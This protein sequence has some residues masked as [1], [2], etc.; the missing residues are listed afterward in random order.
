MMTVMNRYNGW[1][2]V[3]KKDRETMLFKIFK[4]DG[5]TSATECVDIVSKL[6]L[7][8]DQSEFINISIDAKTIAITLNVYNEGRAVDMFYD[9][10]DK[11][12]ARLHLNEYPRSSI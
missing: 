10:A 2:L 6:S 9:L 3:V 1:N 8:S 5:I 4:V 11:I 7:E 12:D